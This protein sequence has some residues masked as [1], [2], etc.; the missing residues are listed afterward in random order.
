MEN[1]LSVSSRDVDAVDSY[2]FDGWE[3]LQV[4]LLEN[5]RV[6]GSGDGETGKKNSFIPTLKYYLAFSVHVS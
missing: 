4:S 5:G 2:P 3:L 6:S 1:G